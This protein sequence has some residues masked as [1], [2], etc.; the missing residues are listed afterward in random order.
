MLRWR[1][2]L[3]LRIVDDALDKYAASNRRRGVFY[4]LLFGSEL[5]LKLDQ[6]ESAVAKL[7]MAKN[8]LI[9]RR[10]DRHLRATLDMAEGRVAA[11]R[12]DR[13][14]AAQLFGR[15]AALF[16]R[17][18]CLDCEAVAHLELADTALSA[19][20]GNR[21]A[22][23]EALA[24]LRLWRSRARYVLSHSQSDADRVMQTLH[25][26]ALHIAE[27][28][29]DGIAAAEL[30]DAGRAEG[31]RRLMVG[32]VGEGVAFAYQT[33]M[34]S[35]AVEHAL[36]TFSRPT[37]RALPDDSTPD[38]FEIDTRR[39]TDDVYERLYAALG[40]IAAGLWDATPAPCGA[41]AGTHVLI[42]EAEVT[43]D[44]V[45]L[46]RVWV[47]ADGREPVAFPALRLSDHHTAWTQ[48]LSSGGFRQMQAAA[49]AKWRDEL[50]DVLL[51]RDLVSQLMRDAPFG[52]LAVVPAAPLWRLPYAAL[53]VEGRPLVEYATICLSPSASM[54]GG[55]TRQPGRGSVLAVE[56]PEDLARSQRSVLGETVS[57]L[58]EAIDLR[59]LRSLLGGHLALR[60]LVLCAH[61]DD[62]P[63]LAHS[64][65]LFGGR[66]RAAQLLSCSFPPNVVLGACFSASVDTTVGAEPFGLPTVALLRGATGVLGTTLPV[67]SDTAGVLLADVYRQLSRGESLADALRAAQLGWLGPNRDGPPEEWAGLVVICGLV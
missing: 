21:S 50:S 11:A 7:E 16:H 65:Q 58:Y 24:G 51:P 8:S 23:A 62:A 39:T 15:A 4:A 27:R 48:I 26:Q 47:P 45:V 67:F 12:L 43:E 9:G 46:H 2:D 54:L 29:G 49:G 61:G 3:A 33:T 22:L 6:I 40:E 35:H 31:L 20:H 38:R 57:P 18:G 42:H 13:R 53:H 66:V 41:P 64:L 28:I 14:R 32:T 60:L 63:G 44:S 10:I 30:I 52:R 37:D 34:L 36:E 56:A 25:W 19:E 59:S 55:L 1:P 17:D 5:H